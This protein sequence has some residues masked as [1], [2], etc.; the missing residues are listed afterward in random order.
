MNATRIIATLSVRSGTLV[1]SIGFEKF[2]PIGRPEVAISFL[3]SWGADELAILD[4][5]ATRTGRTIDPNALREYT[6]YCQTPVAVGGGLRTLNDVEKIIRNGA[7]KVIINTAA[8]DSPKFI[9]EIAKEFGSQAIVVSLDCRKKCDGKNYVYGCSGTYD[10]GIEIRIA[11]RIA[12]DY[13]A[14]EVLVR[15]IDRDGSK[16]GY[17]LG[18]ASLVKETIAIP[19]IISS[20]AS[21]YDHF[22]DAL[23]LNISGMAAGNF[24]HFSEHSMA[25]LKRYLAKK[26]DQQ[27]IRADSGIFCQTATD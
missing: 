26:S 2:L 20:G 25:K 9:S 7:D 19:L 24:F 14:G 1:Q 22:L 5:D 4:I 8:L 27:E 23:S 13:G 12:E 15:S 10:K 16:K 21:S 17:D 11:A 3:N 18:L 6:K